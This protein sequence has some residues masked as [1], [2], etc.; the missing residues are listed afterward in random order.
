M[1]YSGI[2]LPWVYS[3]ITQAPPA[4]VSTIII[5]GQCL[6]LVHWPHPGGQLSFGIMVLVGNYILPILVF[7]YCYGRIAVVIRGRLAVNPAHVAGVTSDPTNQTQ[8]PGPKSSAKERNVVKTIVIISLSYAVCFFPVQINFIMLN[9]G[10]NV[11]LLIGNNDLFLFANM[12]CYLNVVIDPLLYGW[13]YE[14]VR[15]SFR[16]LLRMHCR[17]GRREEGTAATTGTLGMSLTDSRTV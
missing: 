17:G 12:L 16:L 11:N 5:N 10:F 8:H 13:Q 14:T 1:L 3:I 6:N 4:V 9:A 2:A 15:K 7:V